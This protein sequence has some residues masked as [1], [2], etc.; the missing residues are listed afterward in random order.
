MMFSLCLLLEFVQNLL[1]HLEFNQVRV[2]LEYITV[3]RKPDTLY[4]AFF[5]LDMYS[6]LNVSAMNWSPF[7]FFLATRATDFSIET[8]ALSNAASEMS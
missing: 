3:P 5:Y 7:S 8:F 6:H 4:L 1:Y 2:K